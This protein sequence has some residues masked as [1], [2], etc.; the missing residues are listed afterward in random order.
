[1]R[2][3]RFPELR[4]YGWEFDVLYEQHRTL[5]YRRHRL[6]SG[7]SMIDPQFD[8]SRVRDQPGFQKH[9]DRWII[10]EIG[11]LLFISGDRFRVV[12]PSL[13]FLCSSHRGSRA[14]EWR[15]SC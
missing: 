7:M 8:L 10:T 9:V 1:M 6:G 15:K 2:E 3:D 13:Y 5:P 14:Q 12:Q 11:L 4:L